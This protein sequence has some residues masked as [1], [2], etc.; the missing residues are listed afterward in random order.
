M[1]LYNKRDITEMKSIASDLADKISS[2]SDDIVSELEDADRDIELLESKMSS[3][4]KSISDLLHKDGAPFSERLKKRVERYIENRFDINDISLDLQFEGLQEKDILD[5]YDSYNSGLDYLD[6][7][8]GFTTVLDEFKENANSYISFLETIESFLSNPSIKER[9]F[10][11]E[12]RAG[13]IAIKDRK[14]LMYREN[15]RGDILL[16]NPEVYYVREGILGPSGWSVPV[17]IIEEFKAIAVK[18]NSLS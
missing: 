17:E 16:S 8:L 4:E 14:H 5:N 9:H 18:L 11:V 13:I 15:R 10:V 2:F 12:I 7:N 1:Y 3:L 6:D